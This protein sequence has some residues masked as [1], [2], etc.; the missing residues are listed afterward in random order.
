MLP[1][2]GMIA[3]LVLSQNLGKHGAKLLIQDHGGLPPLSM[4]GIR[5]ILE[6]VLL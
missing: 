1:Q 5:F 4:P 2:T 6:A 3:T